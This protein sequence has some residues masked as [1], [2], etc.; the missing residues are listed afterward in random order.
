MRPRKQTRS[1]RLVE[2]RDGVTLAIDV[3]MPA[4]L[5]PGERLPIVLRPTRYHRAAAVRGPL[6]RLHFARPWDLWG[7]ARNR[8]VQAGYAWVD[9]DARGSGASRG[10]RPC[11]WSPDEVM[12]GKDLVD[13]LVKEPWSNGRVGALGISYDGTA[14]EMLLVNAHEAVRAAAPMFSLFDVFRDVAFPGGIHLA[15]FTEAWATYNGLLDRDRF[16]LALAKVVGLIAQSNVAG[17]NLAPEVRT[18]LALAAETWLPKAVAPVVRALVRGV[19]RVEGARIEDALAEHAANANV[20]AF[21]LRMT[22][23]D[24]RGLSEALGPDATI[25]TFSPHHYAREIASSGAALFGI[26]GW[27]D[28]GYA[29]AAIDRHAAVRTPGSK[30]LLGAWTH[31]GKLFH[32]PFAP[33][34]PAAFDFTSELIAFFDEHLKPDARRAPL[35]TVRWAS[36]GDGV[37]G[38]FREA[39]AF[40]LSP[41]ARA[42]WKLGAEGKLVAPGAE[43]SGVAAYAVDRTVGAGF[44]SRWRGLLSLVAAD[45]PDRVDRD[46]RCLVFTSDPLRAALDVV[47]LPRLALTILPDS[48]DAHVFVYLSIVAPNGRVAYLTEGMLRALHRGA[49][50]ARRSAPLDRSF[51]R[52]DAAPLVVNEPTELAIDLLPVAVTI[53]AGHRVRIAIAGTD[54]DH[55][56]APPHDY[57]ELR[58]VL[59]TSRFEL[60]LARADQEHT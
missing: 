57:R 48:S 25:D 28:G 9:V 46:R 14:S 20:H 56:A 53:P 38:T 7:A 29:R 5:A 3:T 58:V 51:A 26:S 52:A 60:P 42:T 27:F 43:A 23:R 45:I 19:R 44:R 22:S 32:A 49:P 11:P 54:K 13:R 50:D 21:A 30:L 55:F 17:S 1:S 24:D 47:G 16:D 41:A 4:D 6:D 34:T 40:P 10:S 15:W 12:D 37:E 39:E 8:F 31:A 2:M 33:P 59:G 36:L 35:P 18:R